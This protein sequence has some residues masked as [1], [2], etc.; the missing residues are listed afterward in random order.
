MLV[1]NTAL[2]YNVKQEDLPLQLVIISDMEFDRCAT[3]ASL[4]N[5]ENAKQRYAEHGYKLPQI[6]FWNV[7]SRHRQVPV[8]MNEQGVILV[9]G[10][11][12]RLFSMIGGEADITPYAMMMEVISSERY[13]A[14]AA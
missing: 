1:L 10:C 6:V 5:F 8:T 11:T 14:I 3:N 12:P 7:A 4:T 9:S 13:A 2:K